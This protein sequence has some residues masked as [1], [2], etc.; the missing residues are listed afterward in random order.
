MTAAHWTE[1]IESFNS[2]LLQPQL[3]PAVLL[4]LLL[5]MLL[6][7]LLLLCSTAVLV[8]AIRHA[9]LVAVIVASAE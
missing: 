9:A 7:L 1:G 6:L 4:M 5:L 3:L 8:E 2:Q